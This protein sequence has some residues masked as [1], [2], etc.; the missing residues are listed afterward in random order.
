MYWVALGVLLLI[1]I[2]YYYVYLYNP[3]PP[4]YANGDVVRC[5]VA[6]YKIENNQARSFNSLDILASYGYPKWRQVDCA[7][8]NK[9]PKGPDMPK[10]VK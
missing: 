6:I 10:L 4:G 8:F 9:I 5:G 1:V 3:L 2:A 7:T